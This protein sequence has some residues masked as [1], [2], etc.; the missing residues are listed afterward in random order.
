MKYIKGTVARLMVKWFESDVKRIEHA[1]NVMEQCE[2]LLSDFSDYDYEIVVACA[3]L[4]DV[5]IKT[6]EKLFGYNNGSLQEEYGPPAAAELLKEIGFSSFKIEK[7][8]EI[9]GNHHSK[10]RYDYVELKILKEADRR[11]NLFKK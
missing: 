1:L 9:I 11:V 2:L 10:S 8:A 4:H 5:G 6:A 3:L 7:V